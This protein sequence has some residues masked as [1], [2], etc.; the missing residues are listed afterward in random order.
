L[1]LYLL[2][3]ISLK[4]VPNQNQ[5]TN[6]PKQYK[7][8]MYGIFCEKKTVFAP[9]QKFPGKKKSTVEFQTVQEHF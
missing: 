2:E 6:Q 9:K 4:V 7:I 3:H 8:V 1:K 5:L